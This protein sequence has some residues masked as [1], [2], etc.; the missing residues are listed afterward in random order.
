MFAKALDLPKFFLSGEPNSIGGGAM[1]G[2]ASEC[3]LVALIAARSRA[4]KKL[5]GKHTHLNESIFLPHLVAYTSEE[6]H[7]CVQKA[8]KMA[9]VR[10]RIIPTDEFGCFRG[11]LLEKT[12]ENDIK[13]GLTPIFVSATVGTTG[14][15]SFDNL[16]EIGQVVQKYPS[17]WFHVD[18]AYGGN[19]FIL[20]EMRHFKE[21]LEYADSFNVN[22]N[23]LLCTS[24]DCSCMWVKDVPGLKDAL[25]VSPEY[26]RQDSNPEVDGE[27]LRH[28]GIPLSRRFRALKLWFVL[29]TYGISG[30]QSYIR[31]HISLAKRFENHIKSDSRFSVTNQV[32]VALVCFKLNVDANQAIADRV[33]MEFLERVNSSGE[34]HM[35][36]TKFHGVYVIRFAITYEFAS[37]EDIG[38]LTATTY[39]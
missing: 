22:P 36:P 7:S 15:G 20:P 11:N 6:A 23:K 38:K 14:T 37:E 2:S 30:L 3:V 29:R 33:N 28:Y 8:A 39:V 25:V 19:T 16:K 35:I 4:V 9:I 5:K 34:I 13:E 32:H 10:L 31:T 26:L 1:Q 21:G 18:G 24:F 27:E 17:I 12:I